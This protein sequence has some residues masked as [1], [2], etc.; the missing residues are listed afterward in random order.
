MPVGARDRVAKEEKFHQESDLAAPDRQGG[1]HARRDCRAPWSPN[2]W[3]PRETEKTVWKRNG[4]QE[5]KGKGEGK[6]GGTGENGEIIGW[7]GLVGCG[8]KWSERNENRPPRK[9]NAKISLKSSR[10]RNA[11]SQFSGC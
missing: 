2:S 5:N 10:K 1:H 4:K 9:Q 8:E 6:R 7:V 11:K 3:K